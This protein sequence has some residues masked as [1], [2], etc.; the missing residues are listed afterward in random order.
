MDRF[1]RS[2]GL[3]GSYSGPEVGLGEA[4]CRRMATQPRV[5]RTPFLDRETDTGSAIYSRVADNFLEEERPAGETVARSQSASG[6]TEFA[7]Y[8]ILRFYAQVK[9]CLES[10]RER[11]RFPVSVK[12]ALQTAGRMGGRAGSPKPVGG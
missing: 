1:I 10:G 11:M 7:H 8:P 9:P 3:S 6:N 5:P 2:H 12:I 4:R